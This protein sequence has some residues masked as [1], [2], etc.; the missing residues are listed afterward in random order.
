MRKRGLRSI[1][2]SMKFIKKI[3]M[4]LLVLVLAACVGV[5]VCA[6]NPQLTESLATM[7]YGNGTV[8]GILSKLNKEEEPKEND[9]TTV[10][11]ADLTYVLTGEVDSVPENVADLNG[12]TPVFGSEDLIGEQEASISLSD[13]GEGD[14]GEN[15][16]FDETIYPYYGMLDENSKRIYRQIYANACNV[17]PAF[18]PVAAIS[19]TKLQDCFEAVMNDHPE[20]FYME[21]SYTVKYLEGGNIVEVD[22]LYYDL[23][24]NLEEAKESFETAA[25]NIVSAARTL[26]EPYFREKLVH[27]ALISLVSYRESAKYNQSAYSALVNHETVCAGYSRA[28]QYCMQQLGIPTYYCTGRTTES[29]A[30]DIVKLDGDYYNVDVT[31]DDTDPST[32]VYFNRTDA[33]Y[34]GNHVRTSLSVNLPACLGTKYRGL[35]D[36][37]AEVEVADDGTIKPQ[38]EDYSFYINDDP[39]TPLRYPDHYPNG[40]YQDI[41]DRDS[42]V[43]DG[44]N[45]GSGNGNGGG[46][47]SGNGSGS[48]GGSSGNGSGNGSGGSGNSGTGSDEDSESSGPTLEETLSSLGLTVDGVEWTM[49]EYYADCLSKLVAAGAGQQH[50]SNVVPAA[51]LSRIESEYGTG[52]Y[53]TGYVNSALTTLGMDHFSILL[54]VQNLGSG[55]YRLYHNVTTWQE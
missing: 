24:D 3:I 39:F 2:F 20:L 31:W 16:T 53:E 30:W 25:D 1:I 27:D 5:L 44:G 45:G 7:L 42:Q 55:Y 52:A 54:E 26:D 38:I 47:S 34:A 10:V 9:L 40:E 17:T 41:T 33:D 37:T 43:A 48:G 22:L 14:T 49:N 36:G 4:F 51:L 13:V 32:Y 28:F 19:V 46:G 29:H 8:E 15:L 23:A 35:E 21:S 6:M 11:L 50:F 12:Y 18:T